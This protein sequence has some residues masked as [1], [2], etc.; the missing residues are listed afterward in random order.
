[1][2][3]KALQFLFLLMNMF[4]PLH[5][6]YWVTFCR[7]LVVAE[8]SCLG[9]QRNDFSAR[10][11]VECEEDNLWEESLEE[12]GSPSCSDA[13]AA[14]TRGAKWQNGNVSIACP[15]QPRMEAESTVMTMC[16]AEKLA[17]QARGSIAEENPL[18]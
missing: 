12:G 4:A 11:T 13:A 3:E 14:D 16:C 17:Y 8:S 18:S 1:M 7:H 5:P 2:K 10:E 9:P 15:W 6:H